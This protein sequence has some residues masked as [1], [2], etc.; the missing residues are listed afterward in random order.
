MNQGWLVV[1]LTSATTICGCM[2]IYGDVIYKFLFP[3]R[4]KKKPFEI[5]N[6]TQFLVCSLALSSGCL[7]FVSLYK[8]LPTSLKYLHKVPSLQNKK[9]L[10]QSTAFIFYVSGIICCSALNLLV[11]LFTS[12]SVVHCVHENNH[13]SG[14]GHHH[15][16]HHN[17]FHN[18]NHQNGSGSSD[19]EN[20]AG[21]Y[22]TKKAEKNP[23][24]TSNP[25]KSSSGTTINAHCPGYKV[26]AHDTKALYPVRNPHQIGAKKVQMQGSSLSGSSTSNSS[27]LRKASVGSS[28]T[29]SASRKQVSALA[30]E[31][32]SVAQ[33]G[34]SS[35]LSVSDSVN[36]ST[37]PSVASLAISRESGVPPQK[38]SVV[39]ASLKALRGQKME[40]DCFGDME[41]CCEEIACKHGLHRHKN[42][43]GIRF[44]CYPSS[45][46]QIFFKQQSGEMVTDKAEL[47]GRFPELE[48]QS[49]L[50]PDSH[51]GAEIN[52]SAEHNDTSGHS[53]SASPGNS[54]HLATENSPL[55]A[56]QDTTTDSITKQ[57]S[58][59]D[60]SVK[61]RE[62]ISAIKD[63]PDEVAAEHIRHHEHHHHHIKTP[64]A[65]L[66]S[67]GL[68]TTLAI[69]MHK[70][71]EGFIMY[72][73]S[74][75]DSKLGW[76]IFLSMFVHNFVEGFTMTLPIYV[77]LNS[78]WKAL[79][80]SG[81]LGGCAQPFGA[82]LGY[83]IFR[84]SGVDVDNPFNIALIGSLMALT[85]GFLT[86]IGLQMLTSSV[87]FG[88]KQE[89]VMKWA[90][91]GICLIF[92]TNIVI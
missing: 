55:L 89:T 62:N 38:Q 40:G 64:L 30:E 19:I 5:A 81:T 84:K 44:C 2:V 22:E 15:D 74:Q 79:L 35:N 20:D 90:L 53:G 11:H 23:A 26:C 70:F 68:Q 49:P 41:C 13:L 43:N 73:T 39:D 1:L 21:L 58:G 59:T 46:N 12:E 82:L 33:A 24:E 57:Y 48:I 61:V 50:L 36:S 18:H 60:A 77:A 4:Y 45:E 47:A 69:T 17:H 63:E 87:S 34:V 16:H 76:T 37:G 88:G 71:P 52:T 10:L 56:A 32:G 78:R 29:P 9:A 72:S 6:N 42:R 31:S 51:T 75:A 83:L 7:S 28:I 27:S 8:L 67:I 66:L 85:S 80:I 65:R 86:Y 25:A 91:S 92:L 3:A 54:D 14:L